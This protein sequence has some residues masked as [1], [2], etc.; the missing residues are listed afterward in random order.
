MPVVNGNYRQWDAHLRIVAFGASDDVEIRIQ[1]EVQ[2]FLDNGFSITSSQSENWKFKKT[3][4][5]S[6]ISLQGIQGVFDNQKSGFV[7]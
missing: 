4:V 6:R 5:V 3:A 1:K 7:G 2:P